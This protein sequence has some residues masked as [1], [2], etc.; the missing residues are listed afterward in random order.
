MPVLSVIVIV[1]NMQREARRTLYS[2]NTIYQTNVKPSDYEVIAIDNGST[3]ALKSDEICNY[4]PNFR[5]Y[6]FATNSASPVDAVNAGVSMAMGK[7]VAV[8]VDG[9]RMATPGLVWSTLKTLR[10]FPE[11]FVCALSWHLGPDIQGMSMQA[12]YDQTEEDR[13]LKSINWPE[14][15]YKLFDIS[16][17]S[18][19]SKDG[20][21]G[22]VPPECSWFAMKKASFLKI[23]GFEKRFQSPGGGFVNHD[24]RNRA[25]S[26]LES[27]PIVLLGEGVFHQ[28]HGGVATN[29]KTQ[30]LPNTLKVFRN[31]Y[32]AIR[33]QKNLFQSTPPV[34]YFGMLSNEARRFVG[35]I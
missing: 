8:I 34:I 10:T 23:G 35:T 5:Y 18:P 7:Y 9:A 13:L 20:F 16:T 22:G 4:G 31:E 21:F 28:F 12:G 1:H 15:G 29:I 19:S 11:P 6:F 32:F 17:I 14:D 2:L 26:N 25:L 27:Q 24:F 30:E 33:K 3:K